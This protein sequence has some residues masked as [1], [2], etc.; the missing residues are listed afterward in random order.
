MKAL[1]TTLT[2][3]GLSMSNLLSFDQTHANFTKLITD[4]AVPTGIKY[5]EL[6]KKHSDLTAYLTDLENVPYADFR[7]WNKNDQ[8]AF[9]INLYNAATLELVLKHYPIR[10]L[11]DEVGG[12][13]GPWKIPAVKM[14]GKHTTLDGLEHEFIRKYYNEPRIHFALNCASEGCPPLLNE[15]YTGEK[16]EKQLDTQTRQF[17]ADKKANSVSG[18][19]LKISPLFDWFK[20][21]FIKKHGSVE[22]FLDPYF[23]KSKIQKGK[24]NISYTDYGWKLNLAK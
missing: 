21:D 1:L 8:L 10:S 19:T 24:M 22:A 12:E 4:T 7:G 17:L 14:F 3:I 6:K 5:P 20:D 2:M 9:L 16:L 23:T 11:K 18:K 13:K 15:A